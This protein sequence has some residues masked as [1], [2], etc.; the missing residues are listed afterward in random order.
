MWCIDNMAR[1]V[2]DSSETYLLDV[3]NWGTVL[4]DHACAVSWVGDMMSCVWAMD[5]AVLGAAHM[6]PYYFNM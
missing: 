2:E 4:G 6:I 3:E 1:Y 5:W